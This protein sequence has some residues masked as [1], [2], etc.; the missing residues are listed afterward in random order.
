MSSIFPSSSCVRPANYVF[1]SIA[2]RKRNETL[3][4]WPG[5]AVPCEAIE[6]CLRRQIKIV[7]FQSRGMNTVVS[8][9]TFLCFFIKKMALKRAIGAFYIFYFFII[10]RG[11]LFPGVPGE[12]GCLL[13]KSLPFQGNDMLFLPLSYR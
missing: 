2:T 4:L 1:M 9:E 11:P 12:K 7:F 5:G 13:C 10:P 8:R 6:A 3:C